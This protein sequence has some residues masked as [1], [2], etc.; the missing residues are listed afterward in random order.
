MFIQ[1]DNLTEE[2]KD[3][4]GTISVLLATMLWGST[5]LFQKMLLDSNIPP[6]Y[7]IG[8][9]FSFVIVL[10]FKYKIHTFSAETWRKGIVMGLALFAAF[11]FQ[12]VGLTQIDVSVSAFLTGLTV[13]LTPII[14]HLIFKSGI[15]FINIICVILALG[16]VY[17]FNINPGVGFEWSMGSILTLLCAVCFSIHVVLSSHFLKKE[18]PLELNVVQNIVCAI[19]GFGTALVAGESFPT[20]WSTSS[21]LGLLYLGL[22]GSVL[23][24][25]LQAWGQKLIKNVVKVGLILTME[26]IFATG[27]AVIFGG[28]VLTHYKIIGMIVITSCLFISELQGLIYEKIFNK[29]GTPS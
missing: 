5:F 29:K 7:M 22:I 24:Y 17:L 25:S 4:Y 28:E 19:A 11:G 10:L 3:R 6:F 26:P 23:C 21:I 15:T 27:L 16:G 20:V 18:D 2:K 8:L 13:V 14:N 1:I 12:T 9:R